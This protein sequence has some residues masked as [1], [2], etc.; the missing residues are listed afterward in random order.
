M[1]VTG[2]FFAR[3]EKYTVHQWIMTLGLLLGATSLLS[4]MLISLIDSW[5]IVV[6]E[7]YTVGIIVTLIHTGLGTLAGSAAIYNVLN[8]KEVLPK[9][10][11]R[12]VR[13]TMRFTFTVWLITFGFGFA[14]YLYYFII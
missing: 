1:I 12:D 11:R 5:H 14:F 6:E 3:R 9:S 13:K 2:F 7:L 8:V 10:L 4:W